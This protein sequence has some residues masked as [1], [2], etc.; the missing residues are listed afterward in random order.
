MVDGLRLLG[1]IDV[2]VLEDIVEGQRLLRVRRR[3]AGHGGQVGAKQGKKSKKM[4]AQNE[5]LRRGK[6]EQLSKKIARG[7]MAGSAAF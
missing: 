5:D 3:S 2:V 1:L 7:E 6:R 4:L